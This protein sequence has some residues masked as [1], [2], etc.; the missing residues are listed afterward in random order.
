MLGKRDGRGRQAA[1]GRRGAGPVSAR[2]AA[3]PSGHAL[4]VGWAAGRWQGGPHAEGA[5][6][7]PAGWGWRGRGGGGP[8]DRGLELV[9]FKREAKLLS[10]E[11]EVRSDLGA[12]STGNPEGQRRQLGPHGALSSR[13]TPK[14]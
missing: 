12:P 6:R 4:Y 8:R 14:P 2:A 1:G 13:T 10:V 7:S 3:V 11:A 9:P 5:G